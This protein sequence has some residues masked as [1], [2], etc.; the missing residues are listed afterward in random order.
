MSFVLSSSVV[1]NVFGVTNRLRQVHAVRGARRKNGWLP[2]MA[3]SRS[4]TVVK[5]STTISKR[6]VFSLYFKTDSNPEK[7]YVQHV[8]DV[9]F[10]IPHLLL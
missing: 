8:P 9:S 4:S 5:T 7:E 2:Q 10:H 3:P 6:I 1:P